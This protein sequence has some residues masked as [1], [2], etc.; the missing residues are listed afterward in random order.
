MQV[1]M[2]MRMVIERG[3][4]GQLRLQRVKADERR[5]RVDVRQ[6]FVADGILALEVGH[7]FLRFVSKSRTVA[8]SLGT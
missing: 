5:M 6:L 8:R 3:N 1:M 4:G 2:M 7:V